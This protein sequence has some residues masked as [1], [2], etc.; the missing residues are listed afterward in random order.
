MP[1]D[2]I[3]RYDVNRN[4][5]MVLTRHDV[6]LS[7]ID[8]SYVGSTI[9]L[10]GELV[11]C[12]GEFQGTG[13]ETLAKE[14]TSLSHVRDIQFDLSNWVI[15]SALGSW[16]VSRSKRGGAMAAGAKQGDAMSDSTHVIEKVEGFAEILHDIEKKKEQE[17]QEV[18]V[19]PGA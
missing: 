8:Y 12:Q 3:S 17:E 14:L 11:K 7:R 16:Q 1:T 13:I 2:Q 10:Y 15:S 6:D 5:R 4:V 9:Y 18:T 19:L